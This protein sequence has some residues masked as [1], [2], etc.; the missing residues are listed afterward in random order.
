MKKHLLGLFIFLIYVSAFAKDAPPLVE[1]GAIDLTDWNFEEQPE[2]P[3]NGSWG[4]AW[5]EFALS[6]DGAKTFIDV[7]GDW[8]DE[9]NGSDFSSTGYATYT[10]KIKLAR[11]VKK[12]GLYIPYAASASRVF[13]NG[14]LVHTLGTVGQTKDST[15]SQMKPV[16]IEL[17]ANSGVLD[18]SIQISNFYHARAG[19][20]TVPSIVSGDSVKKRMIINRMLESLIVSSAITLALYQL[21]IFLILSRKKE[22]LFFIIFALIIAIRVAATGTSILQDWFFM[23]YLLVLRLEYITF[24]LTA[25]A[26]LLTFN[27]QYPKEVN[28]VALILILGLGILYTAVIIFTDSIFFTSLLR[29]QQGIFFLEL[30]YLIYFGVKVSLKKA[31]GWFLLFSGLGCLILAAVYDTINSMMSS[32]KFSMV[33]VGFI[34]FLI[35]QAALQAYM[36]YLEKK[37]SQE[38]SEKVSV[39]A[40]KLSRHFIA[41]KDSIVGLQEGEQMLVESKVGLYE[42]VEAITDYI[43]AVHGRIH[44]QDEIII[45]SKAS[46]DSLDVFLTRLDNGIERQAEKT[47]SSVGNIEKLL[48]KTEELSER[49][50]ILEENFNQISN[51]SREGKDNLSQM[52]F[53]IDS[54]ANKSEVLLE[55]N[56]V[57]TQIAEQTNLLAMNAAIEAAHA[58]DAGKGF[59]VVAEEIRTLAEKSGDEADSTGKILKEIENSIN[60]TVKASGVMETSFSEISDKV[61]EFSEVLQD[62]TKFIK[63]TTSQGTMINDAMHTIITELDLVQTESKNIESTRKKASKNFDNLFTATKEVTEE[64]DGMITHITNLTGAVNKSQYAAEQTRTA[65]NKLT[66]L[67]DSEEIV[68]AEKSAEV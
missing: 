53:T 8:Y 18:I 20:P 64:I 49:F 62:I 32:A 26:M 10:V 9:K 55:T 22:S 65:I 14:E 6:G 2:F 61:S 47:D 3:L 34:G 63:S 16:F 58:G 59:A 56:E 11:E 28:K 37:R 36:Q 60:E 57:I 50:S 29:I 51:A 25:G 31:E 52:V 12:L 27:Y 38:L 54:I 21:L 4:F 15:V 45:E 66:K 19:L 33:P 30:V 48:E 7:P 40:K 39:S 68:E 42:S 67:I 43:D 44:A 35:C 41:I 46:T 23:P 5:Q 24:A 17:K 1:N 13:V